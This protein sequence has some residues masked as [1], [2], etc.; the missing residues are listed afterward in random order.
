[1]STRAANDDWLPMDEHE[2]ALQLAGL[3]RLLGEGAGRLLDL[4]AGAGRI[5][6]P[7]AAMG[8]SVCAVEM[9]PHAARA[10]AAACGGD[11]VDGASGGRVEVRLGDVLDDAV[12]LDVAGAPADG[13]CCLG[14]TLMLFHRMVD[15]VR[16]MG[17]VRASVRPGGWFAIDAMCESVWADV[18]EGLWQTGVSEDGGWQMIWAR[19]ENIVALRRGEEVDASDWEVREGDR[20][21]R[22]WTLGELDLLARATGWG[23][24]EER[25]EEHLIVFRRDDAG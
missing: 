9:D 24:P 22:L 4:G 3:A 11:R 21:L 8:H 13:A 16:L 12:P 17:R 25:P 15:A 1:M 20:L 7:I 14:H 10:C 2:H 19:G 6:A 18:A 5:C 23:A